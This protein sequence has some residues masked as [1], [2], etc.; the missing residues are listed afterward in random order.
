MKKG[1]NPNCSSGMWYLG[2]VMF[3]GFI[4]IPVTLVFSFLISKILLDRHLK[5]YGLS[6]ETETEMLRAKSIDKI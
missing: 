3:L 6:R 2:Y 1:Y 4:A 5:K